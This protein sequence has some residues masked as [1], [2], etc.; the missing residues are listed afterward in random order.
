MLHQ[1]SWCWPSWISV[2][3]RN[4][5]KTQKG[6]FGST[7]NGRDLQW[8]V[9]TIKFELVANLNMLPVNLPLLDFLKNALQLKID[10]IEDMQW[11]PDTRKCGSIFNLNG[12]H[13]QNLQK[14]PDTTPLWF[15]SPATKL[16]K[17]YVFSHVCLSVRHSV[18]S[19]RGGPKWPLPM[20][21]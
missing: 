21:H 5:T 11:K 18:H 9:D 17:G 4:H 1:P 10:G 13:Y 8:K 6:S 12:S 2:V 3:T 15:Y 16:Q 20:M 19:W 14:W 7:I